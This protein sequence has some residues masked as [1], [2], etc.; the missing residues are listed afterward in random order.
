MKK[1]IL[2][3]GEALNKAEQKSING[4]I[5]PVCKSGYFNDQD[6]CRRGYHPH[7]IYGSVAC[8]RD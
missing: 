1:S 5:G 2:N 7:P 6:T 8:C 3:L 4:G